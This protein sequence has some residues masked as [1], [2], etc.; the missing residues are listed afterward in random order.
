[1]S[2]SFSDLRSTFTTDLPLLNPPRPD[3]ADDL[4]RDRILAQRIELAS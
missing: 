3:T 4:E 2:T 1:M